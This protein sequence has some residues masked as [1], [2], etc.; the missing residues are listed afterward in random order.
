M[1]REYTDRQLERMMLGEEENPYVQ[2]YEKSQMNVKLSKAAGHRV[3]ETVVM[4]KKTQPGLDDFVA[5]VAQPADIRDNPDEYDS[6][7]NNKGDIGSPSV[8][9]IPG[10]NPNEVQEL[11]DYGITTITKL[12][13]AKTLPQHLIHVQA[14]GRRIQEALRH[15]QEANEESHSEETSD[16]PSPNR[17]ID[18]APVRRSSVQAGDGSEGGEVAERPHPRGLE[19]GG[20]GLSPN[21]NIQIG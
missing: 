2:F 20:G 4:C 14:S 11:I 21:W 12:C 3:Y 19:Y 7:M 6:F 9:I 16:V 8:D 18:T 10:V 1:S 17:P 13:E 15:E 5:Y